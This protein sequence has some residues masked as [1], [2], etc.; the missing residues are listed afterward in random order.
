MVIV[1][2]VHVSEQNVWIGATDGEEEGVWVFTE[3]SNYP[4]TSVIPEVVHTER[5]QDAQDCARIVDNQVR[6]H[7]C[8]RD[9]YQYICMVN[10]FPG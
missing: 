4:P 3:G 2:S 8:S 7:Y 5:G 9:H 10:P 1:N 6:D